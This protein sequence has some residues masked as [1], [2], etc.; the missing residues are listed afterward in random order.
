MSVA[1]SAKVKLVGTSNVLAALLSGVTVAYS[2]PT[3]D[4]PRELVYG[5]DVTGPVTLAAFAG[6][7][8]I[9][10]TEALT[11][12]LHVRVYR[13]GA[14]RETTDARAAAIGDVI[15]AYIAAN[16]TLGGLSEL[17]KATVD[18][19]ELTGWTDDDGAGSLLNISVGLQSYL[20]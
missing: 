18:A 20:T 14:T 12:L 3:R 11:L 5:G 8:R 6:G 15:G 13:P 17:L 10:R 1:V 7:S 19:I 2:E 4:L 16:W 9:K